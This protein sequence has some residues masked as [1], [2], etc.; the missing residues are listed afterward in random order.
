MQAPIWL[1]GKA[2][3]GPTFR[4]AV[5][6]HA[7]ARL[8]L[9]PYLKNIQVSWTKMGVA[10][11]KYCLNAGANDLGGTLMRESISRA[12]GAT[13]G[14]EFSRVDMR[15]LIY[16]IGRQPIQRTTRYELLEHAV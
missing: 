10:G 5:L 2:R 16:S 8:A 13:Y 11:A 12:A 14:Q 9:N 15:H 6:V 4:E 7:V 3:R 1:K